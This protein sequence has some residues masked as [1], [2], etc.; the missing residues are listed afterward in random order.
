MR[1]GFVSPDFGKHPV[2]CF[3]I[4]ALENLDRSQCEIACYSDRPVGDEL[5][6]RFK[7]AAGLWRDTL[8][9]PAES[10]AEQIRADRIDILF[11]LAGHTARNR[12]LVFARKPAPIQITW[13]GYVGTTGL[14][15]ID[16]LLADRCEVPAEAEPHYRE[17][18]LRL[19]HGYACFDPPADAP[20]VGP[21]PA[22][23]SGSLTFG[24]FNN[25]TKITP[26][27]AATWAGI[28]RRLPTSRLLL[29][30]QGLNSTSAR[31]HFEELFAAHGVGAERLELAGSSPQPELLSCY[32]GVDL[33]LDPFPYSGGLTTCEALWM[34]VPV[35]TCPGE[36][37]AS[38]PR[39]RIGRRPAASG[40]DPLRP[41]PARCRVSAL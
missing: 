30:Y 37:F 26:R 6:A 4:R 7:A 1:L 40:G 20:P 29:K 3:L 34:G 15:A 35:I 5:T 32:N 38:R 17:K 14:E 33:A 36:T 2:G 24:S 10:L 16:Y 39:R 11:D 13:L 27:V 25:P 12:M 41:A 21:L 31:S 19:P 8:G 9:V 18:V 23:S 28:L 22:I